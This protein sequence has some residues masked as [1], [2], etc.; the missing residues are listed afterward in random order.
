MDLVF[1]E[2]HYRRALEHS[3]ETMQQDADNNELAMKQLGNDYHV[4][5]QGYRHV[6][7]SHADMKKGLQNLRTINLTIQSTLSN[8]SSEVA[9]LK[10]KS[11][12]RRF[13]YTSKFVFV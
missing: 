7:D 5:S 2:K 10:Q 12:I 11:G 4:L 8:I 13:I 9:V 1:E 3:V 6:L